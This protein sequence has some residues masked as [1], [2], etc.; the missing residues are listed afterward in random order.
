M[1]FRLPLAI[2][3]EFV[4]SIFPIKSGAQEASKTIYAYWIELATLEKT[5]LAL[6]PIS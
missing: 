5:V 4:V 1:G 2:F 3:A 6:D